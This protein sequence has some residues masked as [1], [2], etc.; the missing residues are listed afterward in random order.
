MTA[1]NKQNAPMK[2]KLNQATAPKPTPKAADK[3]TPAADEKIQALAEEAAH[4]KDVAA[5]AQADM[6]NLRK[7][8]QIDIEKSLKYAAGNFAK[9]LLPV[10]DCLERAADCARQTLATA[11]DKTCATVVENLL[12]GVDMTYQQLLTAMKKQGIERMNALDQPFDPNFHK[13]VQEVEDATHPA[14]TVVQELQPGYT[15][16]GDR[17][18]REAMV[19]VSK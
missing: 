12:T 6:E 10:A 5:R 17:V 9:E 13:A 15:I 14:G 18:L 7:R 2:E 1:Q 3:K 16:G 8:T 4:W 11:A 19:V